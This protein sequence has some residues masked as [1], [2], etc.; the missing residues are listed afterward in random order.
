VAVALHNNRGSLA[1]AQGDSTAAL[2][3]LKQAEQLAALVLGERSPQRGL[4]LFNLAVLTEQEGDPRTAL[5]HYA[6][7]LELVREAW[8]SEHPRCREFQLVLEAAQADVS[9][10]I[11]RDTGNLD[12]QP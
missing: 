9:G 11:S 2:A 5:A 1:L 8:G 4:L 6:L 12:G 7:A 10:V 3:E